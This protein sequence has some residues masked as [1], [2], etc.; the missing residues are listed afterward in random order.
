MAVRSVL[1]RTQRGVHRSNLVLRKGCR[2]FDG[3]FCYA[4]P[5]CYQRHGFAM[6]KPSGDGFGITDRGRETEPLHASTRQGFKPRQTDPE[7]PPTLRSSEVVNLVNNHRLN[8]TQHGTEV[9]A[10]EHQLKRLWCGHEEVWRVSS[11]FRSLGLTRV[12]VPDINA[13]SHGL[14]KFAQAPVNVAIESS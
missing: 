7:L 8:R 4:L 11:L 3:E 1:L 13:Q 10:A 14:G 12:A 6:R 9:F 2:G 5:G